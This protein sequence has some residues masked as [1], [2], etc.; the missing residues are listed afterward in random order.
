MPN[1]IS[2]VAWLGSI[3][4]IWGR[5]FAFFK[6]RKSSND[7]S[8]PVSQVSMRGLIDAITVSPCLGFYP[9]TATLIFLKFLPT[10]ERM[11]YVKKERN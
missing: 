2:G 4:N 5:L 1:T 8:H 11:I 6:E 7:F 9:L 10:F 3:K